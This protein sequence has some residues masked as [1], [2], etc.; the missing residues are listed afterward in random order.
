MGHLSASSATLK[1]KMP[2]SSARSVTGWI[3]QMKQG[4]RAAV[5]KLWERYFQRL[6][7]VARGML[8]AGPPLA[9]Y[10]EDVALGAFDSLVR[11]AE[12]SRFPD[13]TDREAAD[14]EQ[15]LSRE[16]TAEFL[17]EMADQIRQRFDILAD[18]ELRSIALLK[19][20]GY[21]IEEIAQKLGCVPR[22]VQRRLV[23]I[24]KTWEQ[25]L[26]P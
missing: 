5:A 14:L 26:T 13:L 15:I 12:A 18:T 21:N 8:H 22:T 1:R 19:M 6:V 23:R 7:R 3:E 11:G 16:P 24:R 17:A 4:D 25:E 2:M 9:D 10:D 20:E